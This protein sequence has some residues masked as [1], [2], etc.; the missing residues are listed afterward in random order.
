MRQRRNTIMN[1]PAGTPSDAVVAFVGAIGADHRL[2]IPPS[3]GQQLGI[4][5]G[6]LL[7]LAADPATRTLGITPLANLVPSA[8]EW[9]TLLATAGKE[10][11]VDAEAEDRSAATRRDRGQE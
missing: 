9:R 7:V 5:P 2:P 10:V 11:I 3:L 4:R 6:T 1:Q 8:R